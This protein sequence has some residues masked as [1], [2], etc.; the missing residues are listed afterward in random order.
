VE[1]DALASRR[2]GSEKKDAE[3]SLIAALQPKLRR[4][5]R[6][7][8]TTRAEASVGSLAGPDNGTVAAVGSARA[9]P[10]PDDVVERSPAAAGRRARL[11]LLVARFV[12][13]AAPVGAVYAL[14][15]LGSEGAV[16]ASA[17]LATAIWFTALRAAYTL[18]KPSPFALGVPVTSAIGTLAGLVAVPLVM[19]WIPGMTLTPAAVLVTGLGVFVASVLVEQLALRHGLNRRRLLMVGRHDGAVALVNRLGEHPELPFDCL[20]VVGDPDDLEP[21]PGARLLGRLTELDEIVR[22][23]QPDL[24]VLDESRLRPEAMDRLLDGGE[25]RLRVVGLPEFYEHAFGLVPVRDI[26]PA[27]FMSVMHLYKRPGSRITKRTFDLVLSGLGLLLIAP[28][29]VAAG[30]AVRS[31]GP[32]PIL[33]RQTR[34]GEAGAIFEMLKFRT[35]I[36]GAEEPNSPVWAGVNDPRVTTVG[37]FLRNTRLDEIPQLWNVLRGDM[38]LIGPRPER[39]EFLELLERNVPFWTRRHLVK[40]GVTGWAQVQHGYASGLDGTT[41]KLSYDLY[42]LKHRSVLLDVIIVAKTLPTLVSGNGAR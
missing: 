2:E 13:V 30:I 41:E 24:V 25:Q 31:S 40:P 17:A 26:S 9:T 16:G 3:P 18:A 28:V 20:G 34:V 29:L 4:L 14:W 35:M 6:V 10:S 7:R 33:F 5:S 39:P 27:W 38:S 8:S 23:Q 19:F 12:A 37:R 11:L 15:P 1:P 42:Y 22:R 32:G 36:Q 21:L